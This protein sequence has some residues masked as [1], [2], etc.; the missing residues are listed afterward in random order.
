MNNSIKIEQFSKN[1]L[2]L[3]LVD[4]GPDL[5][6]QFPQT[7]TRTAVQLR[8]YIVTVSIDISMHRR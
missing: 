5:Q 7:L 1:V 8:L 4:Q 2:V 3:L 6:V